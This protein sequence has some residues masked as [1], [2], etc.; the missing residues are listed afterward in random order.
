MEWLVNK[1]TSDNRVDS[2]AFVL[3]LRQRATSLNAISSVINSDV[4]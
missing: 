1:S 3:Y 4:K 2:K